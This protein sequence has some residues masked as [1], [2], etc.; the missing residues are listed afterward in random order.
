MDV[1]NDQ[2]RH[3]MSPLQGCY[4]QSTTT[5]YAASSWTQWPA[6]EK[7]TTSSLP[8]RKCSACY[9]QYGPIKHKI[10]LNRELLQ[11]K[12]YSYKRRPNTYIYIRFEDYKTEARKVQRWPQHQQPPTLQQTEVKTLLY[13]TRWSSESNK[14]DNPRQREPFPPGQI[15][16]GFARPDALQ[17]TVHEHKVHWRLEDIKRSSAATVTYSK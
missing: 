15:P 16:G 11:L 8:L 5:F 3:S 7:K 17:K 4:D 9:A 6:A 12:S 2:R 10:K 13:G 1:S 14:H